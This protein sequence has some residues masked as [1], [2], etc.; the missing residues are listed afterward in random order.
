MDVKARESTRPSS[1]R[2]R[3]V[4]D[5][6]DAEGSGRG[7]HRQQLP[8]LSRVGTITAIAAASLVALLYSDRVCSPIGF[9]RS[10]R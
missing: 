4:V 3:G 7:G 10:Y 8:A 1:I 9:S 2:R 5:H 6:H